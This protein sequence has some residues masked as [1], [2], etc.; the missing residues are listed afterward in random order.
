MP[1]HCCLPVATRCHSTSPR[2][3]P[4]EGLGSAMD[5]ESGG[6]QA[7]AQRRCRAI[8][9]FLG[10]DAGKQNPTFLQ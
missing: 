5:S 6:G 1:L 9:V 10:T 4:E 8:G 2:S 3:S 7:T